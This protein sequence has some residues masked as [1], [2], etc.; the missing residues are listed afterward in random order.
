MTT[1][2]AASQAPEKFGSFIDAILFHASKAPNDPA[3]GLE[4]GVL[5]YTQ[6]ADAIFSAT[7][8]CEKLGL[9]PDSIVAL[10]V[11]DPVWHIC[12]IA[13]LYRLGIVSV[14]LAPEELPVLA[15]GVVAATLHDG[16]GGE[17][18]NGV[19]V[20]GNWFTQRTTVIA[21]EAPF[22]AHD[23]CRIA[24]SSGT[25]GLP[26]PIALS[27][28]I[29]WHRLTTYS[30]RGR[31]AS[32]DRI[33]CGPQLRSQFGFAIAFSGLA[34]GKM[35][36]F[37]NTAASAIP[38]MSYFK[39]DL[40]IVS[41]YQLSEIAEVMATQ[42]GGLSGLREIQAGGALISDTLLQR[43]RARLSAEVVS[44][45]ASTEAGTVAFAPVEQLGAARGEGAVGFVVPWATVEI[46]DDDNRRMPA[47]RDGHIRVSTLGMAPVF[48]PGMR[49]VETPPP[50]FPGDFGR[51]LNNGMLVVGGRSTEVINI[52]GNKVSPD[53][54]EHILMQCEGVRDAAVFT[55]DIN[56][57]LPQVWAAIV[58]EPS[59]NVADVMKRCFVVPMIGT[60]SV[61]R[62][63]NEI[64]RNS[65]G[66][67][68]RDRLR[69]EL[70]ETKNR[71]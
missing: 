61:L 10:I 53:R 49:K 4:S 40:A 15:D 23:L 29:V 11:N 28:S 67:I 12:L 56:S 14:S 5:T 65:S 7:A 2:H 21:G 32:S 19:K 68:M 37:S 44:T 64:P 8:R 34:Y 66:K 17:I 36:C 58:A 6:L 51:L 69:Q 26:K 27:P 20:E 54:F 55:V 24:L 25:T 3:I 41:V 16:N 43:T 70:T 45:Y 22:A 59:V 60:P 9:R 13:A 47:G 52:G 35:V 63:V 39:T 38:V 46:L 31:F 57:A 1:S 62:V 71:T 42:Y 18:A 50:F 30:F 33:F 48:V